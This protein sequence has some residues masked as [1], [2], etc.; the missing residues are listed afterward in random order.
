MVFGTPQTICLQHDDRASILVPHENLWPAVLFL[1]QLGKLNARKTLCDG[2]LCF[3]SMRRRKRTRTTELA[4]ARRRC[5][6]PR[7]T[8]SSGNESLNGWDPDW[9]YER[10][11]ERTNERMNERTDEPTGA[12]VGVLL[13]SKYFSHVKGCTFFGSQYFLLKVSNYQLASCFTTYLVVH[14]V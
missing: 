14:L 2:I 3:F 5:W 8:L 9:R 11:N 13:S 10:T 1:V 12:T 4:T 7:S 6:K